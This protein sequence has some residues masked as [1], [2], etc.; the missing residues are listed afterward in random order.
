MRCISSSHVA[1][2]IHIPPMFIS[3]WGMLWHY[4]WSFVLR[5]I[6]RTPRCFPQ[7]ESA[8]E[9]HNEDKIVVVQKKHA[10]LKEIEYELF[11]MKIQKD[12]TI[13]PLWDYIKESLNCYLDEI[14]HAAN[15]QYSKKDY[16]IWAFQPTTYT[17]R[18][19]PLA[20]P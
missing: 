11:S 2:F 13:L 18:R 17:F 15:Y 20:H 5:K 12:I 6:W 9:N 1:Y 3:Y 10:N 7:V 4:V 8:E 19:T 14:T 16:D